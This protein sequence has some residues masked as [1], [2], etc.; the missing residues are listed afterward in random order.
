LLCRKHLTCAPLLRHGKNLLPAVALDRQL[1]YYDAQARGSKQVAV[2]RAL[3]SE[4]NK[5]EGPAMRRIV[6]IVLVPSILLVGCKQ[7]E[8]PVVVEEGA[9]A[10][11]IEVTSPAFEE[12]AMIPAKYTA[13]GP[14]VSPPLKWEGIPEAT[15]SIALISDDPDAPVGT[16]VHWIMWNIPPDTEGLAE[17]VPTDQ[18][19]PDGS[20]QGINGFG[21]TG[22]GGPA[23]PSGTHRYYFKVYALDTK[24]D[25]PAD[26]KKSDLVSA[27]KDQVLAQGQLMGKYKRQ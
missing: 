26:S 8:E 9:E 10:M 24:L 4:H 14:N 15:K 1:A 17:D 21:D 23:P 7:E 19:L 18:E 12:D 16:W 20:V 25:L 6:Y 13:D 27:M 11:T 22:Y 3:T 5:L 2:A